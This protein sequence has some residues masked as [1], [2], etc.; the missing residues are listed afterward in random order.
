M[1]P[2]CH[3]VAP[4]FFLQL[5]SISFVHSFHFSVP[6]GRVLNMT[7]LP[8]AKQG[9]WWNAGAIRLSYGF[10]GPNLMA[11]YME[12]ETLC[13]TKL[14]TTTYIFKEMGNISSQSSPSTSKD[15]R[16]F[17]SEHDLPPLHRIVTLHTPDGDS[18]VGIEDYIQTK[19]GEFKVAKLFQK[20]VLAA[21]SV[22]MG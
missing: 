14:Q 13:L 7:M 3:F 2:L 18:T 16:T 1:L 19:V 17:S 12:E 10:P 22:R 15:A 8:P 11:T 5:N 6:I 21:L 4:S 9:A 20:A